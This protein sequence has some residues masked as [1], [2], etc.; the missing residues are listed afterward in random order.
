MI[1]IV[2]I[3]S[4]YHIELLLQNDINPE[5]FLLTQKN[6]KLINLLNKNFRNFKL[7]FLCSEKKEGNIFLTRKFNKNLYETSKK[8]FLNLRFDCLILFTDNKP[9]DKFFIDFCLDNKIRIE[10]WEDGLG[11]YIGSGT[12]KSILKNVL[13][14]IYGYYGNNIL[15][16]THKRN[17]IIIKNRFDK[18]NI[19]YKTK[20]GKNKSNIKLNEILF[21][22]QPLVED[23]YISSK[24]Y[25]NKI[26]FLNNFFNVKVNYLPHPRENLD[27]YKQC[28]LF[29]VNTDLDAET[30]CCLNS[31]KFYIS[32]FSTTLLNI[33]CYDK[34]FYIPNYFGLTKINKLL[35]TLSFLPITVA[36]KLEDVK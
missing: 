16:D 23:G 30:Y 14:Y 35:N 25:I 20:K 8:E 29:L 17:Q 22:G 24:S 19:D 6:E 32:V 5:Y 28:K 27:K 26:I 12:N 1:T 36:N 2:K 13:K 18:K 15:K 21:I 4:T 9:F 33:D 7:I 31:Y 11:H 34:S 3:N 10:L